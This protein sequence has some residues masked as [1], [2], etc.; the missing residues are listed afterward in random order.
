MGGTHYGLSWLAWLPYVLSQSGLGLLPFALS[1][2][3]GI[4]GAFLG[5]CFSGFLM[6]AVTEGKSGVRQLWRRIFMWRVGWH[7]PLFLTS[8][9]ALGASWQVICLFILSVMSHA[10]LLTWVYN[11]TRGSVF[12]AI[13]LHS[14]LDAFT[15]VFWL[16][17][18]PT[19]LKQGY[20]I[21]LIGLGGM[22]LLLSIVT[23]GRLGHPQ[24][25]S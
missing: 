7:L 2:V 9:A 3:S 14:N 13:L 21:T 4:P 23:R 6:T 25:K 18:F 17:L 1:Q 24:I 12:I 16:S 15:S 20:L 8:W 5:P 10:I 19:F 22:A 11:R